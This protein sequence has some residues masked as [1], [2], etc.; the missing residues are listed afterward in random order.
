[1]DFNPPLEVTDFSGGFT[2]NYLDA[3]PNQAQVVENFLIQK[4]KK[5][6]SRV[7]TLIYDSTAYQ[8]PAGN[9]RIGRLIFHP[10]TEL[11]VQSA[12]ALYYINST[13]QTLTGPVDSNQ[14]FSANLITNYISTTR[15]KNHVY[16]VSDSFA[17][18]IKVYKDSG[19]VWRVNT[20]G[21]PA[22]DLEGA[23]DLANNIKLKYNT[24]RTQAG[25]HAANDTT[26]VISSADAFDFDTLVTLVTELT[27]D[28][29]AHFTDAALA[30]AWAFHF[31]QESPTS[32][33]SDVTAVTTLDQIL[34]RLDALKSHYNTHDANATTHHA[35]SANQ[36]AVVRTPAITAS[37]GT[38]NYL[39]KF[40]YRH[41]YTVGDVTFEVLG[42]TLE[43]EALLL[44]TG[45]KTIS[46]IPAIANGTTRC[47]DT[48]T[49]T[50]E[51]YRTEDAG[52]VF[53]Y[54]GR[55]T[56]GTTTFSDTVTDALLV[57]NPTIYTNGG[58]LDHDT[59]PRA[60]F[61]HV[62]N[63]VAIFLNVKEGAVNYSARYRLSIPDSPDSCPASLGDDMEVPGTGANSVGIYPILFGRD[64]TYRLEGIFDELGRGTVQLREISRTKGCISNNS[65]VQIPGG[66]VFAGV[67]QFYFTDGYN[68][69][70]IDT[71]HVES[72]KALV[73]LAAYE[74]KISGRYDS[75]EN[76]VYWC[77]ADGTTNADN[78]KLWILDLNFQTALTPNSSFVKF[79]NVDSWSPTDIEFYTNSSATRLTV[80]SDT[81]GYLF[82]FDSNT[83]TDPD[84]NVAVNPSTWATNQ[85][86]YDYR[87]FATSFG[88]ISSFKFVPNITLQA[89]NVGDVTVQINSNNE[90]SGLFV[91]LKEI[92]TRGGITWGDPN[93]IW[94]DPLIDYPWNVNKLIRVLRLFPSRSLRMIYKQ[95]QITNAYTIIFNSDTLGTGDINA[96]A[97]TLT[98]TDASQTLPTEVVNYFVSFAYDNYTNDFEIT[99][100]SS[101]TALVFS[102]PSNLSVTALASKWVI[103]GYRKGEQLNLLSYSLTNALVGQH[104][105]VYRGITGGNV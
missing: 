56:N 20:A 68:V 39:Y 94:N 42:A 77:V 34:T 59:P 50:C 62:V 37:V 33:L 71:H 89:K 93:V 32:V 91:P 11:F 82:K 103:K 54:V 40:L 23:I 19:N 51:I 6:I 70:P 30:A 21:L 99:T 102:D 14:A 49:I 105:D 5:L 104:Q 28:I 76:R 24:H 100:R 78:N 4:N 48:A 52:S 10:Q 26:N 79:A 65:I 17:D 92:R 61:I 97:K 66:L 96:T 13:Y 86:I 45:T 84:I 46:S 75:Q 58:A 15:W 81:R 64:R 2:D 25:R 57:D 44:G 74:L 88:T 67:D 87:S 7:G 53:Y 38:A 63:G 35:G 73:S 16:M 9:Q 80:L 36:V 8:I 72:Y 47:Y 85:V 1:M 29:Q 55:V 18:P 98:L 41:T 27:T 3:Q 22:V 95:V 83:F 101:A 12:R 90:D 60:K 31:A 43:V 69:T